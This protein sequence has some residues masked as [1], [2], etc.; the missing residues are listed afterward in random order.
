M[1]SKD[2]KKKD[3]PETLD[4]LPPGAHAPSSIST[5][6]PSEKPADVVPSPGAL[7][8]P[9]GQVNDPK[10]SPKEQTLRAMA[11]SQLGPRRDGYRRVRL[12]ENV[13]VDGVHRFKGDFA[14]V[15]EA[16]FRS[17][18]SHVEEV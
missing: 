13:T 9:E 5:G 6:A 16:D 17:L 11:D 12:T 8:P 7:P 10:A 1:A 4:G 14:D 3:Q 18:R 15:P 2:E